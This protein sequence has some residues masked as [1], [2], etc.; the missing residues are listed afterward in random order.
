MSLQD[1]KG[2]T[3]ELQTLAAQLNVTNGPS[4]SAL[5]YFAWLAYQQGASDHL[6]SGAVS[7][8]DFASF[9]TTQY[10]QKDLGQ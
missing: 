8:Q 10:T 5:E 3:A 6:Q 2:W 7:Q 9:I 4:F 1:G